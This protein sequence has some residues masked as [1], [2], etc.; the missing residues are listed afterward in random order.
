[1]SIFDKRHN[2]L[3]LAVGI[4]TVESGKK[5]QIS[6]DRYQISGKAKDERQGVC[7]AYDN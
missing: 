6:G 1:M 4:K 5:E 2:S 3:R 7:K